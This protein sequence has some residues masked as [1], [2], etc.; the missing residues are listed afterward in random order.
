MVDEMSLGLAPVVVQRLLPRLS[1]IAHTTGCGVLLVEQHVQQ[2]LAVADR[3][4][5]LAHG[6]LVAEGDAQHLR[7]NRALLESTYLGQ[8]SL[9]A[10]PPEPSV[11]PTAEDAR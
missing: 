8:E 7:K 10:L 3:G 6:D 2:A 5:V 1:K 11:D 4:Y 9:E